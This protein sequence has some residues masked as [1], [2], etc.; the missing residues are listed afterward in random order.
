MCALRSNCAF[1]GTYT[2]SRAGEEDQRSEVCGALVAQGAGGVDQSSDTVGLDGTADEG[3]SPCGGGTGSLL[4]LD[5]LLFRVGGLGAVIGVAEDRG[6]N[7]QGSCVGEERT[8]G[9]S[10]GLNGRKV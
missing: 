8:Q 4:G 2:G 3:A 6:Q 10:R 1:L 7:A 5:K 9:N